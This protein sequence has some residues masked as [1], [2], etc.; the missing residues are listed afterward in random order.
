[1]N[2]VAPELAARDEQIAAAERDLDAA[3]SRWRTQPRWSRSCTTVSTC[4]PG[5]SWPSSLIPASAPTASP[6]GR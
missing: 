3:Q 2:R 6:P 4:P 1:M 5:R